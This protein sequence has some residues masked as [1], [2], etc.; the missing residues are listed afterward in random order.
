MKRVSQNDE[1]SYTEEKKMIK[2]LPE[3]TG[4]VIG[5]EITGKVTLEEENGM[6]A[7]FDA[8]VAEHGKVSALVI[9]GEEAGWGLKAGLADMKWLLTHMKNLNK[10]A[11]VTDSSVY[12]W[13]VKTDAQFAKLV[14]I[15]EKHFEMAQLA[16]A[17]AWVKS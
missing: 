7:K 13:L 12:K 9:L 1:F 2:E 5:V 11:I 15:G 4:S 8:A 17:W 10:I 3:S 14:N 16:D 6:I